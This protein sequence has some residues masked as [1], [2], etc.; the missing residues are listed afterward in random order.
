MKTFAIRRKSGSG[1]FTEE[2][3]KRFLILLSIYETCRYREIDFLEFLRSGRTDLLSYP[4]PIIG[5][6]GV[7]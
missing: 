2:G 3:M 4:S 6:I 1:F 7:D 5:T